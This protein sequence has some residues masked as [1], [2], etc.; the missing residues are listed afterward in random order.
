VTHYS[1]ILFVGLILM[2]TENM[3]FT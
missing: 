3:V 1:G 2:N